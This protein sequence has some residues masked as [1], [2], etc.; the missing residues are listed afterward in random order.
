MWG[1]GCGVLGL[2]GLR[3]W[4]LADMVLGFGVL[5]SGLGV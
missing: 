1:V 5:G 2:R 3:V 4:G